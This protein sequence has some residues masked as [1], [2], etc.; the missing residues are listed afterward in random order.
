M[1][2]KSK[3]HYR[4]GEM[5]TGHGGLF[6]RAESGTICRSCHKMNNRLPLRDKGLHW[7]KTGETAGKYKIAMLRRTL[8]NSCIPPLPLSFKRIA[9][10]VD[11]I[12]GGIAIWYRCLTTGGLQTWAHLA[13]SSSSVEMSFKSI[14]EY[15]LT[16]DGEGWGTVNLKSSWEQVWHCVICCSLHRLHSVSLYSTIKIK[17]TLARYTPDVVALFHTLYMF[18]HDLVER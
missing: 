11:R 16:Q 2:F 13:S 18:I 14:S 6:S 1:R 10:P 4:A 7:E 12:Y 3:R 17:V 15:P 5:E 8:N 9:I